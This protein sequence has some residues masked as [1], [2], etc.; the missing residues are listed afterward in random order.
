MP[1]TTVLRQSL[2]TLAALFGVSAVQAEIEHGTFSVD[3]NGGSPR[4]TLQ[5]G[6]SENTT[7]ARTNPGDYHIKLGVDDA[8][9]S[10]VM[11]A[12][13]PKNGTSQ[14]VHASV[15]FD[16]VNSPT[17]PDDIHLE[18]FLSLHRSTSGAE[19]DIDVAFAYFPYDEFIGGYA[20]NTSN[21]G[22]LNTFQG[23]E[24]LRLGS[25]IFTDSSGT[26]G[27]YDLNLQ[28]V[29]P[30]YSSNSGILLVTAGKNDDNFGMSSARPD[31]TFLL[32]VKDNG[33]DD[34]LFENDGIGF[35]Y[36]PQDLRH[37]QIPA[38]GRVTGTGNKV[39]SY[40]NF[41]VEKSATEGIW[42]L[43]IPGHTAD[44]GTLIIS[45]DFA[46]TGG[47]TI[48]NLW[49]YQWNPTNS[50]WEI[51]GRDIE[52]S[53]VQPQNIGNVPIFSFAFITRPR[54]YVD[55][56][57][58]GDNNGTSWAHA[59]TSLVTALNA[60]EEGTEIWV[61]AGTYR[62]SNTDDRDDSLTL[63]KGVEVY[64]GF[65]GTELTLD[66]RNHR[67]NTTILTADNEGT[68][69]TSTD[70]SYRVV[71]MYD[72]TRLD[73]FTITDGYNDRTAAFADGGGAHVSGSE[74]ATIA[75]CRF[76]GNTTLEG[77]G[78]GLYV[79]PGM[80]VNILNCS[81]KGN[82]AKAG[83]A[84][85]IDT[86]PGSSAS[87][88]EFQGNYAVESG[89]AIHTL[90]FFEM[91]NCSIQGNRTDGEGGAII[92]GAQ[93]GIVQEIRNSIIWENQDGTNSGA[94]F[95]FL[96]F[97]SI[98]VFSSR[99]QNGITSDGKFKT[100]DP[101]FAYPIDPTLAP[102]TE[103]S[104]I[105]RTT[106]PFIDEGDEDDRVGDTDVSGFARVTGDT[107][108]LGAHEHVAPTEKVA[109]IGATDGSPTVASNWIQNILSDGYSQS[110]HLAET[111]GDIAFDA[112]PTVNTETGDLSFT[113]T[114]GT[115]GFA[116]FT[117]LLT[118]NDARERLQAVDFTVKTAGQTIYVDAN[119]ETG[120]RSGSSW[121]NA[122]PTLA[123]ALEYAQSG[124]TIYVAQGRYY[125]GNAAIYAT[126]DRNAT[127]QLKSGVAIYGGFPTGGSSLEERNYSELQSTLEG[128]AILYHVVTGSG[129]DATAILDGFTIR[130]GF[131]GTDA[132]N[133][134]GVGMLNDAGSPT[135]RNCIFKGNIALPSA[136][137][138][139]ICNMN[140]SSP[141]ITNCTFLDNRGPGAGIA[142]LENSNPIVTDCVFEDNYG[143]E[144]GGAIYNL[145]SNPQFINCTFRNNSA[146][147]GGAVHNLNSNPTFSNSRF[148]ANQG[149]TYGGAVYTADSEPIFDN[150]EF[151]SNN[152]SRNGGAF[153]VSDSGTVTLKDCKLIRN[154]SNSSGSAIYKVNDATLD[155]SGTLFES[156]FNDTS[157]G[158]GI[159]ISAG[160]A[161][162]DDVEFVDNSAGSGGALNA[163]F[164]EVV[165]KDSTFA[166]NFASRAAA[167]LAD[168]ATIDIQSTR[169]L[170]NRAL[171]RGGAIEA[172]KSTV[173]I[174][175][176]IF[177]HNRTSSGSGGAIVIDE[178]SSVSLLN[179]TVT[180]NR[181]EQGGA[182]WTES[183]VAL[184]NSIFWNNKRSQDNAPSHVDG[185]GGFAP[186]S[187]N[188][189]IQGLPGGFDPLFIHA[190][191]PAESD[192]PEDPELI[193]YGNLRL[194][195]DSP[196]VDA[197]A[198]P[199]E[200]TTLDLGGNPRIQNDTIDIGAYEGFRDDYF[201]L[202]GQFEPDDDYNNN[203]YT[204]WEDYAHG[205]DPTSK[206][207]PIRYGRVFVHNGV[208]KLSFMHR[209]D[210]EDVFTIWE[211]STSLEPNSWEPLERN[212][213]YGNRDI[214][215][216][217]GYQEHRFHLKPL[218]GPR[219][220]YRQTLQATQP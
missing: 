78:G 100:G 115:T 198:N 123:T 118:P 113:L 63:K 193:N 16:H 144:F 166:R 106:S 207:N 178:E 43:T 136:R 122:N 41:F 215:N 19:T 51:E 79:G 154:Q 55:Q 22:N 201:H 27:Q 52:P 28:I 95:A 141:T 39:V 153:F 13:L 148:I 104:L 62:A 171:S 31:G 186:E 86:G 61:A 85:Y 112:L 167:V 35:V 209:P 66:Q 92:Y 179:T 18:Y 147:L 80:R 30:S 120:N 10:G 126:N 44:T 142:N 9:L 192:T 24:G 40:G 175:N 162:F 121:S 151:Q 6:S 140:G 165:I 105:L 32:R 124:D 135:I 203:G 187:A 149:T 200:P 72:N 103:G 176:S 197:G 168:Q 59:Y 2:F 190:P 132:A 218:Q 114:P 159:F 157:S 5:E 164:C 29:N 185:P 208:M 199:A 125:P 183:P 33:A 54:L 82:Q 38:F 84:A 173:D 184:T 89:G 49:S 42:Y 36:L 93:D 67:A 47:A 191:T 108:D 21:N 212:T 169:F 139:A 188:N 130:D 94:Q 23:S 91:T 119:T 196:A 81:F 182:I 8:Y 150:C 156:N 14:T 181:A 206:H 117:V 220:F 57:A 65:D 211:Q 87:N 45:P 3:P 7:V 76:I 174:T 1:L 11:M 160:S 177:V 34:D 69:E 152:A 71:T 25:G 194:S 64:G 97:N 26:T 111:T 195:P 216:G 20:H 109:N 12:S 205:A 129:T 170:G 99:I 4:L 161:N 101:R 133:P 96:S 163:F 102:T 98:N 155:V 74:S 50:R 138:A 70:N 127:F 107:I 90:R 217:S 210:R 56:S 58:F 189:I 73:G 15:S 214:L 180:E 60:A 145:N 37:P 53:T 68:P 131:P 158:G 17:E 88:S 213:H 143:E 137:G 83:G 75:N 110:I 77:N 202:F 134:N 128:D 172:I 219:I 48:D 146:D 204:N 116:T 46:P